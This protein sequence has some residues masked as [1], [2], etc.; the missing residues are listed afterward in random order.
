MYNVKY[1]FADNVEKEEKKRSA[2]NS[3]IKLAYVVLQCCNP[4]VGVKR[5]MHIQLYMQCLQ[6][7]TPCVLGQRSVMWA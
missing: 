4:K 2:Q 5:D 7:K 1:Y 3:F 6:K